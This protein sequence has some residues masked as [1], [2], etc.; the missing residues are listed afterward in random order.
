[1]SKFN[2]KRAWNFDGAKRQ[3]STQDLAQA[4]DPDSDFGKAMSV[5]V[6]AYGGDGEPIGVGLPTGGTT[7]QVLKKA[8][9]A[10]GDATWQDEE[11]ITKE[12]VG[13]GNVAN[14]APADLGI[15]DDVQ[16]A[17]EL[18]L[19]ADATL[20]SLSNVS[21]TPAGDEQVMMY[22]DDDDT[23]KPVSIDTRYAQADPSTG[24]VLPDKAAP[25]TMFGFVVEEGGNP[26]DGIAEVLGLGLPIIGFEYEAPPSLIPVKLAENSARAANNVVLTFPD[27]VA[28]G[29]KFVLAFMWSNEAN[30]DNWTHAFSGGAAATVTKHTAAVVGT[31]CGVQLALVEVTTS[32]PVDGTMTITVRN[33]INSAINRVHMAAIATEI[34]NVAADSPFDKEK[35]ATGSSSSNMTSVTTGNTAADTVQAREVVIAAAAWNSGASPTSRVLSGTNGNLLVDDHK[36]DNGSSA[37]SLA[38]FY[39]VLEAVGRANLT[40]SMSATD[41]DTGQWAAT[42]ATYKAAE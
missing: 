42:L 7:G 23:W 3:L 22:D 37:R 5:A 9:D 21:D 16:A 33:S 32:I 31:T 20:S 10:N 17:L 26:P 11:E 39:K 6:P 15:S 8:S 18:K 30:Y 38:V 25:F 28:A 12:T 2:F 41:N 34:I 29:R 19:D 13:L 36:S 35:Q 27:G 4:G 1:M 40:T 14:L 24:Q